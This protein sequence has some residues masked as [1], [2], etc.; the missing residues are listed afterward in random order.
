MISRGGSRLAGIEYTGESGVSRSCVE[1]VMRYILFGDRISEVAILTHKN[2]HCLL[3]R[4]N[5]RS[6]VAVKS[7]FAS[8]Y[9]GEGPRSFDYVLRLLQRHGAEIDEYEVPQTLLDRLDQSA[10]TVSDIESIRTRQPVRPARWYDYINYHHPKAPQEIWKEF[11]E[12][13]PYS[14]IDNRILDLATDFFTDPDARLLSGYRRLE[15]IVRKRTGVDEHG[16]R[17]F[18]QVFQGKDAKLTWEGLDPGEKD[19]R[20]LLFTA[21]YKTFRN[22][23]AHREIRHTANQQLIEF[24]FLNSLFILESTASELVCEEVKP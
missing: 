5:Q 13:I 4:V 9:S 21:T 2:S 7:G 11:P 12:A 1:A 17:L 18:S 24:L 16:S 3:L 8:G 10:L 19:G 20:A 6:H 14:I 23:R 15:D 22:P